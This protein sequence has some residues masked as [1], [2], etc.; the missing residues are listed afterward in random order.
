[1]IRMVSELLLLV[2]PFAS[3]V[4]EGA[5]LADWDENF[6][7]SIPSFLLPTTH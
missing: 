7:F 4:W 6:Q 3:L 1:M 2:S 5:A